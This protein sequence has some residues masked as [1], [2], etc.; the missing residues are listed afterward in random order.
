MVLDGIAHL[1][2]REELGDF[3][4]PQGEG[5]AL[6]VGDAVIVG[7]GDDV[8][9]YAEKVGGGTE[10]DLTQVHL[11]RVGLLDAVDL[12][13]GPNLHDLGQVGFVRADITRGRSIAFAVAIRRP[14]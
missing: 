5:T 8:D 1:S 4:V 6:G 10:L 13:A 3:L 7:V 11:H 2:R 14:V 12:R 9:R